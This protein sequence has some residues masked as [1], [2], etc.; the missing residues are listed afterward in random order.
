MGNMLSE[1]A[2][3]VIG[4]DSD[5]EHYYDPSSVALLE[6]PQVGTLGD[7]YA[8]F[9][10]EGDPDAELATI[11]RDRSTFVA[12]LFVPAGN[13]LAAQFGDFP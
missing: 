1:Y 5:A 11:I 2:F 8:A 7:Y 3:E 13:G 12:T 6:V 4:F 9:K 10:A